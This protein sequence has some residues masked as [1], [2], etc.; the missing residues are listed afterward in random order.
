MVKDFFLA[1]R[2]LLCYLRRRTGCR[3]CLH[4]PWRLLGHILVPLLSFP[5]PNALLV[6]PF[7]SIAFLQCLTFILFIYFNPLFL[8]TA[9]LLPW[10]PLPFPPFLPPFDDSLWEEVLIPAHTLMIDQPLSTLCSYRAIALKQISPYFIY[11]FNPED[12]TTNLHPRSL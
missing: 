8:F 10:L 12:I 7:T 3:S 4:G 5:S 6:P 1:H 9:A 2:R 11:N